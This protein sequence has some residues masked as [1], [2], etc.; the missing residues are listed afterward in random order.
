MLRS[1]LAGWAEALEFLEPGSKDIAIGL[2]IGSSISLLRL[3]LPLNWNCLSYPF[4][5]SFS[6]YFTG[7]S[8]LSSS[9]QFWTRII[10]VT[11]SDFRSSSLTIRNRLP[12]GETSQSRTAP[13]EA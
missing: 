6:G 3:Q 2:S 1:V 9:S 11:G 13:H 8:R 12:S 5:S 4:A 10:S 7:T